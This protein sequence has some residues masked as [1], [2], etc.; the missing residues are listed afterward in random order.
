MFKDEAS[1]VRA[2]L[3]SAR[4]HV[5]TWCVS[6]T[7]STD[8]TPGI[9]VETMRDHLPGVVRGH[10]PIMTTLKRRHVSVFDFAANRNRVLELAEKEEPRPVF[11]LFLS[12]H[13]TLH[14][15]G[16]ALRKFLEEHR[17]APHGAYCVEMRSGTRSWPFTR[18]LRVDGGWRYA[19]KIHECPSGP[20][21]EIMGPLIPGVVIEHAPPPEDAERKLRRILEHDLPTL[22]DEVED[23]SLSL[24]ARAPAIRFLAETHALIAAARKERDGAELL[25]GGPWLSHTMAAMAL[26]WRYAQIGD[27]P[28]RPGYDPHPVNYALAMFFDLAG[29][30]PG[31]YTHVE[32]AQRLEMFATKVAPKLPEAHFLLAKSTV[33]TGLKTAWK[34]GLYRAI[35]A[36]KAARAIKSDG[37]YTEITDV[38]IEWRSLLLAAS[39]ALRLQDEATSHEEKIQKK[40]QARKL[41]DAAVKAGAP[42]E[43]LEGATTE[44][45]GVV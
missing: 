35:E 7:G 26:Y 38:S 23:E 24:E 6:D 41:M 12:G 22:E 14:V 18:V 45:E 19:G 33:K 8:G 5:D 29:E 39:C 32:L 15:D 20:K 40:A 27:K 42:R 43:V 9:V 25:S 30:V 36:A 17:D 2:V 10:Q 1:N 34:L 28:Q 21:G 11:T 16:D 4:T 3:E 13:E 44:G 37:T 31:L